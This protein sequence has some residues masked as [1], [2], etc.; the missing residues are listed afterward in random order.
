MV[1]FG[2]SD[3]MIKIKW[4]NQ[5]LTTGLTVIFCYLFK[6]ELLQ[7]KIF[8]VFLAFEE[9]DKIMV[10]CKKGIKGGKGAKDKRQTRKE[11]G[12]K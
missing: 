5:T 4:I 11:Q 1:D 2:E 8:L 7:T 10:K 6:E 9:L 12:G 3:E